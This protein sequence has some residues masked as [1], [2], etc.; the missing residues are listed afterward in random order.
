[1]TNLSLVSAAVLARTVVVEG[2]GV[3]GAVGAVGVVVV[4]VEVLAL[5]LAGGSKILS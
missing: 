2:T 3:L 4:V 1:M 5:V